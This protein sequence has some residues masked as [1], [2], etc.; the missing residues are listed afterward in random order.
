MKN[1]NE[2][3]TM[4]PF[5]YPE[6][7]PLKDNEFSTDPSWWRVVKEE[8]EKYVFFC[9]SGALEGKECKAEI[10]KDEYEN[11]LNGNITANDICHKYYI[12]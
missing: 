6:P 10:T 11:L 12:G 9:L 1:M 8:N 2:Y 4:K 3:Y 7:T 5:S